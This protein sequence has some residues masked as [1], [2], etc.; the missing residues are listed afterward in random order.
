MELFRSTAVEDYRD[1]VSSLVLYYDALARI[2]V[3]PQSFLENHAKGDALSTKH[4]ETFIARTTDLKSLESG[5]YKVVHDPDF[6]YEYNW[7]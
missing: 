2:G 6:R 3:E 1:V 4:I 5:G 7:R